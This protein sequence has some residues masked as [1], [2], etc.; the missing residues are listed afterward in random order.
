MLHMH[1]ARLSCVDHALCQDLQV[2]GRS[3][4]KALLKW[5]ASMGPQ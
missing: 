3:K 4:F 2:L 5:C 1:P